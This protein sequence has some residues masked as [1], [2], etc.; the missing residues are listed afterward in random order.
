LNASHRFWS[1]VIPLIAAAPST[2]HAEVMTCTAT[3]AWR[4]EIEG[5]AAHPTGPR[6]YADAGTLVV[7]V[8][9]GTL[10][11]GTG[12][13]SGAILVSTFDSSPGGN[14]VFAVPDG[15]LVFRARQLDGGTPYLLLD[16]YD[17]YVGECQR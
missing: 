4:L 14:L 5:L 11:S 13:I 3:M 6:G 16:T 9:E 2:I 15:S 7:D 1:L 8:A 10:S 17:L 12:P